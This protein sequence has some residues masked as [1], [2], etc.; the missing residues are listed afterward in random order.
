MSTMSLKYFIF[1]QDPEL[2]LFENLMINSISITNM[3]ML[4]AHVTTKVCCK[5]CSVHDYNIHCSK[6]LKNIQ[7]LS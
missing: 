5:L 7:G 4:H 6:Y 1:I 2:Y 3:F